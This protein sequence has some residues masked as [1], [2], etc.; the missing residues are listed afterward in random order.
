[1]RCAREIAEADGPATWRLLAASI[2]EE[3]SPGT[4]GRR[5]RDEA[6]RVAV[7]EAAETL[8][9]SVCVQ[10]G[11]AAAAG[12]SEHGRRAVQT[13]IERV[14]GCTPMWLFSL[15][16]RDF[17]SG[18]AGASPGLAGTAVLAG[19]VSALRLPP[20]TAVLMRRTARVRRDAALWRRLCLTGARRLVESPCLL[21]R[22]LGA[23]LLARAA[24]GREDHLDA[25]FTRREVDRLRWLALPR[26]LSVWPLAP[27][28]TE[29]W[30]GMLADEVG[31]LRRVEQVTLG[32]PDLP[33]P[34]SRLW[35]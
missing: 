26:S 23:G 4:G 21:E 31:F 34:P 2:L 30:Q 12:P 25:E 27:L 16:T 20:T 13:A 7:A 11:A 19:A 29:V 17:L 22:F 6:V 35:V 8:P 5:R 32:P 15:A 10:L 9:G 3:A 1:M 24:T 33:K 28:Q 18:L 14:E